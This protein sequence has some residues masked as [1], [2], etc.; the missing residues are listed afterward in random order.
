MELCSVWR[1][2]Q[3]MVQKKGWKSCVVSSKGTRRGCR[4]RVGGLLDGK[5]YIWARLIST[6]ITISHWLIKSRPGLSDKTRRTK[7]CNTDPVTLTHFEVES[8]PITM[9]TDKMWTIAT[10][11]TIP[12]NVETIHS[13]VFL[14]YL[15]P[16]RQKHT[17]H[18]LMEV[19]WYV[20]RFGKKTQDWF[21]SYLQ[22]RT[23]CVQFKGKYRTQYQLLMVSFKGVSWGPYFLLNSLTSVD[24]AF[25]CPAPKVVH[26]N[27]P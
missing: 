8:P 26:L 14:G 1:E 17:T 18:N 25:E 9:F 11:A 24:V 7:I 21:R 22:G 12:N 13:G 19:I 16:V 3:W 15:N 10:G 20:F 6:V 27:S 4:Y 2:Y 5:C 23:Q